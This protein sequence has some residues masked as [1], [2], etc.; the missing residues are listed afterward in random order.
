MRRNGKIFSTSILEILGN[1]EL[2]KV[3]SSEGSISRSNK[4]LLKNMVI[5]AM[6]NFSSKLVAFILVPL[7]TAYLTTAECGMYDLSWSMIQLVL[8]VITM[9]VVDSSMAFYI[10]KRERKEAITSIV[11]IHIAIGLIVM[12]LVMWILA[13]T[14]AIPGL[15]G[16]EG[17]ILLYFAV[18]CISQFLFNYSKGMEK[19]IIIA[20]A[21]AIGA[22]AVLVLNILLLSVYHLGLKGFYWANIAGQGSAII[23][24]IVCHKY[25]VIL[26]DRVR[27]KVSSK[28]FY[29]DEKDIIQLDDDSLT[30][31]KKRNR[32][33]IDCMLWRQLLLYSI[34]LI[35][36]TLSWWVNNALD[37]YI[38]A[39]LCGTAATGLLAV[40]YK[41]PSILNVIQ[42][43]FIQSWHISGVSEY[44]KKGSVDF[45]RKVF[46]YLNAVLSLCCGLIILF[47]RSIARI[48]FSGDFY[49]AWRYTPLLLVSSVISGAAGF[50]APIL[51]AEF[52]SKSMAKSGIYGA[53][54]NAVLNLVLVNSIGIQ[55]AIVATVIST[56][57]IYIVR[58]RAVSKEIL[59]KSYPMILI[60]WFQ[61]ILLAVLEIFDVNIKWLCLIYVSI[62]VNYGY[63]I[64]KEVGGEMHHNIATKSD[65]S[66]AEQQ[67]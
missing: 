66:K 59:V 42:Q 3:D 46:L 19:T 12:C 56:M 45:Y 1:T 41:L 18:Y 44:G 52:D 64:K 26:Q 23:V 39:W 11:L 57:V 16:Y 48:M 13:A 9:N 37:K 31:F 65:K 2:N 51:S 21:S 20:I 60:S 24:Y 27:T 50:F 55:G 6:G 10:R 38:V 28:P 43:I 35:A 67:E 33:H 47:C 8:P 4:Y 53:L 5:I 54:T 30:S 22:I 17:L 7:Y 15:R 34:P 62:L 25:D 29:S 36:V 32:F 40:S 58:K 61:L 49:E 63:I 14:N